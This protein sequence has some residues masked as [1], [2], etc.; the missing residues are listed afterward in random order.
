MERP[1][2]CDAF[3]KRLFQC[4]IV[5]CFRFDPATMSDERTAPVDAGTLKPS[6]SAVYRGSG[7]F[8]LEYATRSHRKSGQHCGAR[9][10]D[11]VSRLAREAWLAPGTFHFARIQSQ[12][13]LRRLGGGD[14]LLFMP[15]ALPLHRQIAVKVTSLA[16]GG[17]SPLRIPGDPFMSPQMAKDPRLRDEP[18]FR[19]LVR[20]LRGRESCRRMRFS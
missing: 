14:N 8:R 4:G 20:D 6:S 10:W 9:E 13:R 3:L 17:R 19:V 12:T 16:C 2:L 15:P 1:S 5:W 7:H 11:A 18:N